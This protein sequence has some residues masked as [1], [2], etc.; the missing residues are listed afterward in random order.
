M[1]APQEEIPTPT[2]SVDV[3]GVRLN[4]IDAGDGPPVLMLHG[5]PDSSRLWR[6]QVPALI[7]EGHRVIA[8]DLRGFGESER[9]KGLRNYAMRRILA[10]LDGLL[11]SL[12]IEAVDLVGHDWGAIA[13]W[14]FA[15]WYPH[16]V[17]RL[18]AISVGHP[19]S[20]VRL[21][22]RQIARSWYAAAF[23]IPYLGESLFRAFD[24]RLLRATFGRSPDFEQYLQDLSRP[25]ALTSGLNWYRANHPL[26]LR[27][28][29]SIH[30]PTLG[31]WGSKDWA[32]T[33][34]QMIRSERFV[35]GPWRYERV[36]GGHWIPLR[37]A[38]VL[39]EMLLA[40]F[41][42]KGS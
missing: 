9:P 3:G 22:P 38:D 30:A 33:E 21:G 7:R 17:I 26:T 32:L 35:E 25:G 40:F 41:R 42:V 39:N 6:K 27:N 2:R 28:Y 29:P 37:C 11:D 31:I 1:T 13:S 14:G 12:G 36:E 5:F 16:R 19:R 15:G 20:F 18:V 23:L 10:D 4:V 8:P 34:H 24:W